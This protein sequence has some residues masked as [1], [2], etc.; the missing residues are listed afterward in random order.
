MNVPVSPDLTVRDLHEWAGM[1]A[2]RLRRGL[3]ANAASYPAFV[4][5]QAAKLA[6]EVGELQAEVLGH[7]GYQRKSKGAAFTAETIGSE[8]A[9][10]LICTAILASSHGVD[11]GKAVAAKIEK[12][13]ARHHDGAA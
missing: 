10:V 1:Q 12:I 5:S 3:D 8:L 13:E 9:D 7:A 4:L 11:L 6:E 2:G